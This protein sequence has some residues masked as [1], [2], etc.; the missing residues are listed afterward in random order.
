MT[1]TTMPPPPTWHIKENLPGVNNLHA[2]VTRLGR[3]PDSLTTYRLADGLRSLAELESVG[4]PLSQ[5]AIVLAGARSHDGQWR[6]S[7]ACPRCG[8]AHIHA[9]GDAAAPVFGERL[10]PCGGAPYH[11]RFD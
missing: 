4:V 7:V 10:P 11:L 9:A 5:T 2:L 8:L 6:L 1:G 3:N